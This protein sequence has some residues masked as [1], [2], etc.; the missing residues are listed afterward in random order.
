MRVD[1]IGGSTVT[2]MGLG[3]H[4]GGLASARF[5]AERGARVTVTDLR[6][7][8]VLKP[9]IDKLTDLPIRYVLGRHEAADFT[10][11][12]FVIKN[13][14]VKMDS[15]YL[16]QA[17]RIETDI[18]VF[19]QFHTGP[20]IAVTGTKG[21]STTSSAIHHVLKSVAPRSKLGGNI[22]VSP[23]QFIATDGPNDYPVVLEL[24]SWQLADLQG[25]ELLSP[26]V[27]VIT[28]ILRDHQNHY[29]SI[30]DYV[31]DKMTIFEAQRPGQA[32]IFNYDDPVLLERSRAVSG[33]PLYVSS[34]P[35]PP[36]I[37]GAYLKDNLG[38]LR[39]AEG[40]ATILESRLLRGAHNAMNLLT[41]ALASASF[42]ISAEII[43]SEL[44]TFA[45][46][47][48]RLEFVR[49]VR[50]VDFFNDSAATIPDATLAAVDSF[51]KDVLLIAGGTDKE[52][53]FGDFSSLTKGIKGIYLLGGSATTKMIAALDIAKIPYK[54][55]FSS[56]ENL[57]GYI[58]GVA[59]PGDI[60]V[61]SP[62]CASF[63]MFKNEFDR[64]EKFK[65]IVRGL[66]E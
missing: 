1:S 10:E 21:K 54:G 43:R 33:A 20:L 14:A 4:G 37:C 18:S 56:L 6:N 28:N 34:A 41:A 31:D 27:A 12:D 42:G 46:I 64:G 61:F 58:M 63:G 19:L 50:G 35:L 44:S 65:G 57:I 29:S 22:T 25:R 26:D 30:A 47:E 38:I 53:D 8:D 2:I 17:A 16:R 51:S 52:L 39:S 5:F 60:V 15:P 32:A 9:S 55:P 13:P 66:A 11:A 40:E 49:S 23:L 62:G 36:E 48:H 3:L 59:G 45:G 7:E 24:S